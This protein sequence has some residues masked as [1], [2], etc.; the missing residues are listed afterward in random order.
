MARVVPAHP[1]LPVA[2]EPHDVEVGDEHVEAEAHQLL[3]EGHLGAAVRVGVRGGGEGG[4]WVWVWV[5]V[6]VRV[7]V[8]VRVRVRVRLGSGP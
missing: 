3:E 7:G 6:R 8:R 2:A 4:V 5:W 1:P